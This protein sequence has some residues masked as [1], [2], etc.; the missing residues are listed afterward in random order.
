MILNNVNCARKHSVSRFHPQISQEISNLVA[1][2]LDMIEDNGLIVVEMVFYGLH[3]GLKPPAF[4]Y[5]PG[6]TPI[7]KLF[8]N[9][10]ENFGVPFNFQGLE[11]EILG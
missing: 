11:V 3:P 4:G 2:P 7:L 9:V 8:G 1:I 6:M 10:D 5:F